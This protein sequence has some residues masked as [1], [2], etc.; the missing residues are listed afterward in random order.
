MSAVAAIIRLDVKGITRDHVMLI[1]VGL[2]TAVMIVITVLG[3][4]QASLSGWADWFPFMVALSLVSGPGGFGYMFGLLMVDEN[5]TGVRDALAVMPV[6]PTTMILTRT[7]FA[8]GWMVVW[9]LVTISIM[10]STW[11][12]LELSP[13][14]YVTVVGSLA[15]LTPALALAVPVLASDKVEA[16]A[17]FKGLSFIMLV[18]VGLYF[19]EPD[20]W[21]RHLFLISPTGW[22]V[23]AFDAFIANEA[24]G[25]LW[26]LGGTCYAVV[27]LLIAVLSFRRNVY[28]LS[29]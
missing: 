6:P 14:E 21:Y 5:D 29:A 23:E 17:V 19:V 10:N 20:A 3:L 9:P 28:G 26:A 12:V 27:L 18:P 13:I 24:A 22:A 7:A 11:Q 16:L 2:S 1:N 25:Y 15:L 4:F 8:T